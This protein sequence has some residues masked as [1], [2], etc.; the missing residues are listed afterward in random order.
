M[1]GKE[2]IIGVKAGAITGLLLGG[3]VIP[4][5]LLVYGWSFFSGPEL[6]TFP[7]RWVPVVLLGFFFIDALALIL[8]VFI[9]CII[10]VLFVWVKRVIPGQSVIR[11]SI[12]LFLVLWLLVNVALYVNR[13]FSDLMIIGSTLTWDLVF[14]IVFGYLFTRFSKASVEGS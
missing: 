12:I 13:G 11:Q 2:L 1:A 10:G 9:L 3:L 14:A 5:L 7:S 8:S 6:R 4:S